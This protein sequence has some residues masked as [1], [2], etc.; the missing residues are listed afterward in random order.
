MSF[1]TA[2]L[3]SAALGASAIP[4]F[5]QTASGLASQSQ[6][7][8]GPLSTERPLTFE[9]ASIKPFVPHAPDTRQGKGSS[10]PLG[11][12]TMDP[13]RIHYRAIRLKDL[14]INAYSVKD[15]QIVGPNWL[16]DDETTRFTIEATM[17]PDTTK[18]QLRVMLQSMLADRFKLRIHRETRD[19]PKYSLVVSKNGPK[20]KE[21]AEVHAPTGDAPSVPRGGRPT[22]KYDA[23]GFPIW[24][25]PPEGGIGSLLI[26]GRGRISGERVSMHDLAN[27]LSKDILDIP[28]TDA[29]GL[30]AKYDFSLFFSR[31]IPDVPTDNELAREIA[32]AVPWAANLPEGLPDIFAAVQSQLGLK[33][34]RTKGPVEVIVIDQIERTPTEN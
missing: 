30:Q 34:E 22:G 9:V 11:P 20:M 10:G 6:K 29:T 33:L 24:Q 13:G 17:P 5:P 27:V 28:V 19:L 7:G 25:Y 1:Q 16:N 12:G 3:V 31:P 32:R 4:V 18:E 23:F 2:L 8:A 15:F 26:N 21:T 14:V